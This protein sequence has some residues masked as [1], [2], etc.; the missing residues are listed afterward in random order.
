CESHRTITTPGVTSPISSKP[1]SR[2]HRRLQ[3][4]ATMGYLRRR[5]PIDSGPPRR[6]NFHDSHCTMR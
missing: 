4:P 1:Q 6:S 2:Q 3:D 5:S